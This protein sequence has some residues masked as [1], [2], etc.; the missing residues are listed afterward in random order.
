[1]SESNLAHRVHGTVNRFWYTGSSPIK[2]L[3]GLH[4]IRHC[5]WATLCGEPVSQ[6]EPLLRRPVSKPLASVLVLRNGPSSACWGNLGPSFSGSRRSVLI[7]R[8]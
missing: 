8:S 4:P 7:I 2:R 3:L 6:K 5:T 1:M